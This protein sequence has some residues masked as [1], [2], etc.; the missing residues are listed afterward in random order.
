[1][2]GAS[3]SGCVL[4]PALQSRRSNRSAAA[5]AFRTP[6]LLLPPAK[7]RACNFVNFCVKRW[8]TARVCR[9]PARCIT[10]A[11]IGAMSPISSLSAASSTTR[12][13]IWSSGTKPTPAKAHF[14]RSQHELIGVFRSPAARTETTSNFGRF[15]R[16][17]SNVWTYAGVNS[18]GHGRMEALRTSDR[19]AD[20]ACRGRAAR[21]HRPRRSRSRSIRGFWHDHPGGGKGRTEQRAASKL[22]RVT[23]MLHHALAT[24]TKLDAVLADDGRT[25]EEVCAARTETITSSLNDG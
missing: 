22:S 10:S 12:C 3:R 24:A 19:K 2:A 21:L 7:C 8:G 20:R 1:M 16:N 6:N 17:R 23:S 14:Y 9:L 25:F 11:W 15:G 13:S 4:R 18:F 5:A